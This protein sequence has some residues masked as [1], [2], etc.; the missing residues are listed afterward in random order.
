VIWL[1]RPLCSRSWHLQDMSRRPRKRK[2]CMRSC[3]RCYV[4]GNYIDSRRNLCDRNFPRY[5]R[6]YSRGLCACSAPGFRAP[7][8]KSLI[9]TMTPQLFNGSLFDCCGVPGSSRRI[10]FPLFRASGHEMSSSWDPLKFPSQTL[11]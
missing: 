8:G 4:H 10:W 11:T 6:L 1:W 3:P 9:C 5:S 2:M 7:Q